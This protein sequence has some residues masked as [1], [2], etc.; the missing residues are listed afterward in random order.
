LRFS[1]KEIWRKTPYQITTLFRIH[2][3]FNPDRFKP[4][5]LAAGDELDKML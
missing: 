3:S 1:E 2:R 5:P 4:E